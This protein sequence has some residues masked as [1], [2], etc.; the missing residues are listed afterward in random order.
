ML[1]TGSIAGCGADNSAGSSQANGAFSPAG[2]FPIN[3]VPGI[4]AISSTSSSQGGIG[5]ST[6][7]PP[8]SASGPGT[9]TP[10]VTVR[11][12][13]L[14]VAWQAPTQNSDGTPLTDLKGFKVYYGPAS[15]TYSDSIQVANPG[16]TDFV[17][18]SLPPGTYYFAVTAY[19]VDGDESAPSP[20]VSAIVL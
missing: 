16:I 13:T 12:G 20:E 6:S 5:G 14:T 10:P 7:A 4:G 1:V 8:P 19:N 3:R 11:S 9:V 2:V 15:R 17:V 18:Q